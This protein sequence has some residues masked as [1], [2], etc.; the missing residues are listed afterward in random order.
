MYYKAVNA[1]YEVRELVMD[2][3]IRR[4]LEFALAY[5]HL[6]DT[7]LD[8]DEAHGTEDERNHTSDNTVDEDDIPLYQKGL[9]D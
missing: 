5:G 4:L 7:L 8:A 6:P 1:E 2:A 3:E 9:W